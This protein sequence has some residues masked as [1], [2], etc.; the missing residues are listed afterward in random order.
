[1]GYRN[2]NDGNVRFKYETTNQS[3]VFFTDT[4][5]MTGITNVNGATLAGFDA[6]YMIGPFS[7]QGLPG[8]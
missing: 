2:L 4:N 6:A 1:V 5:A 7:V 3:S 8:M